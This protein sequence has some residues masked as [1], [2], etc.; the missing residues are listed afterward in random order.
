GRARRDGVFAALSGGPCAWRVGQGRPDGAE[1]SVR[2]RIFFAPGTAALFRAELFRRLG[3]FDEAFESY[4]EDVDLGL[5]CALAGLSGWYVPEAVA[6]HR[7][8]YTLGRWRPRTVRLIACNQVRIVA[9]HYPARLIV[10]YAWPILIA[11]LLWGLVA[12]RH[13]TG[14]AWL[15][16]KFEAV[17]RASRTVPANAAELR[18]VLEISE[19]EILCAQVK[20]G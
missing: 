13:G 3:G 12:L 17:T 1:F 11:Q 8:S 14:W 4:L 6:W 15:R 20:T 18:R 5:R 10:R 19:R 2:R 16:G 7:G 9:K